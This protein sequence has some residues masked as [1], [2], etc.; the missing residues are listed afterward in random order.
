MSEPWVGVDFDGTLA[1]YNG[2]KGDNHLGE[3]IAAMVWRIK[4][5]LSQNI[6]VKIFTARVGCS[7]YDNGEGLDDEAF[8]SKQRELIK[9]WCRKHIGQELEVTATKDFHMIELWDDRAIHVISNTSDYLGKS[10][11]GFSNSVHTNAI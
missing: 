11:V 3:P 1:I 4:D 9:E 5:W 7:G 10:R 2:W 6:K 8:A